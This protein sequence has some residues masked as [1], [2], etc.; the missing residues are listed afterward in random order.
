[1]FE[2]K[3]FLFFDVV[4]IYVLDFLAGVA[5]SVKLTS[6]FQN[7]S[8]HILRIQEKNGKLFVLKHQIQEKTL[9]R[10]LKKLCLSFSN[11]MPL[12]DYKVLKARNC[13]RK[14]W[15]KNL[16]HWVVNW[17]YLQATSNHWPDILF[18][19]KTMRFVVSLQLWK[20]IT[21]VR[22]VPCYKRQW[23]ESPGNQFRIKAFESWWRL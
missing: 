13:K 7:K 1:M 5:V 16:M 17:S 3:G 23:S 10:Q 14:I 21:A 6:G 19:C 9:G 4:S 8:H 11:T 2:S 20:L 22:F 12:T 15:T 18:V